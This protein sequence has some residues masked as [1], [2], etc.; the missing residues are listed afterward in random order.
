MHHLHC[1]Y[2]GHNLATKRRSMRLAGADVHF[3]SSDFSE[4]RNAAD[5]TVL[6]G[7]SR[8]PVLWDP[9]PAM[10]L[11][12]GRMLYAH[13]FWGASAPRDGIE[14][15]KSTSFD[16]PAAE[17]PRLDRRDF[18]VMAR[19]VIITA[20]GRLAA[21]IEEQLIDLE[22]D[23][24]ERSAGRT[25]SMVPAITAAFWQAARV[26]DVHRYLQDQSRPMVVRGPECAPWL[27]E[28]PGAMEKVINQAVMELFVWYVVR[29]RRLRYGVELA[30]NEAPARAAYLVPWRLLRPASG[31][32]TLDMRI[33]V[34]PKTVRRLVH[35]YKDQWLLALPP[36][37]RPLEVINNGHP[38]LQ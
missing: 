24:I 38:R 3:Q 16:L 36:D 37:K 33:R 23:L 28:H 5:R 1:S 30:W 18:I 11:A 7:E 32:V 14:V 20:F 19:S 13:T 9:G 12:L 4:L 6:A 10:N 25:D 22:L 15:W 17:G 31:K 2:C 29:N 34:S 35:R 21:L 26:F 27:P 8:S